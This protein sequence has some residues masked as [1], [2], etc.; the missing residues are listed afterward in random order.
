[1]GKAKDVSELKIVHVLKNGQIVDS[2]KGKVVKV[3][4]EVLEGSL[5][6]LMAEKERKEQDE[7]NK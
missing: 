1:M 4:M 2:I 7:K 5:R 6:R 3:P